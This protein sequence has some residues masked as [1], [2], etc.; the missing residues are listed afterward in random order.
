MSGICGWISGPQEA[1]WAQASVDGMRRALRDGEATGPPPFLRGACALAVEPGIRPVSLNQAE[2][3]LAAVEGRVR[4]RSASLGALAVERGAAAALAEA[5]R[6]HGSD[7]LKEMSG[8]FAIAVV[9]SEILK[10]MMK[11]AAI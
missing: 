5:Y 2:G 11:G 4:W 10:T 9:D 1:G 7:C 6:Q 8:P 3:L